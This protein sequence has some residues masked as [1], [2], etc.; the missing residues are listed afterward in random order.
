MFL[1]KLTQKCDKKKTKYKIFIFDF[2]IDKK[3][4]LKW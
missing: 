3:K 4:S 1:V 2:F